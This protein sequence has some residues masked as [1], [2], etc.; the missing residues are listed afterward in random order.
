M[1]QGGSGLGMNIVYN[2]VT[3]VLGGTI[4]IASTPGKGTS[5]TMVLPKDAPRPAVLA[6]N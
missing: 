6:A 3:G 5:V 4:A 1:G 2:L